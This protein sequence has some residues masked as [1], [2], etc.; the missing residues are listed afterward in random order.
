M[1][2]N[3]LFVVLRG[4]VLANERKG[5]IRVSIPHCQLVRNKFEL[6]I[7][8][9]ANLKQFYSFA[10]MSC[11]NCCLNK[12]VAAVVVDKELVKLL[13]FLQRKIIR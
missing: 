2:L 3:R 6:E 7:L 10:L 12:F 13:T 4:F 11:L 9:D 5:G 8:K 1:S